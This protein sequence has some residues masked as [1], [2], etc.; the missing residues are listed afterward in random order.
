MRRIRCSCERV[1]PHLQSS[2]AYNLLLVLG[3]WQEIVSGNVTENVM[4]S[5]HIRSFLWPWYQHHITIYEVVKCWRSRPFHSTVPCRKLFKNSCLAYYCSPLSNPLPSS[6]SIIYL[7]KMAETWIP[8]GALQLT[9]LDPRLS[10][11]GIPPPP[12]LKQEAV[13][14]GEPLAAEWKR[15]GEADLCSES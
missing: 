11:K 7:G 5:V 2:I 1:T 3:L 15:Q 6:L 4:L 9:G 12:A 10:G 14:S 8:E 13:T